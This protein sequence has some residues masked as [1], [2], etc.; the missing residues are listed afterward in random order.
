MDAVAKAVEEFESQDPKGSLSYQK[1]ADKWHVERSTVARRHQSKGRSRITKKL[2]QR[3]L[4]PTKERE[5]VRYLN[6]LSKR[7]LPPTRE[8]IINFGSEHAAW[9]L[10]ES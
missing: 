10:G 9:E 4:T 5:L 7:S 8:M 3:A 2:N 1:V 6:G